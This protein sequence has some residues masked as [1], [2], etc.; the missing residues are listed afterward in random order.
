MVLIQNLVQNETIRVRKKIKNSF[1]YLFLL[2]GSI[3]LYGIITELTLL[4]TGQQLASYRGLD[5]VGTISIE[6]I[7]LII[8]EIFT[9]FASLCLGN[10]YELSYNVLLKAGYTIAFLFW[11]IESIICVYIVEPKTK[12]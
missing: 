12:N 3:I 1:K 8:K 2:V 5:N 11:L 7:G 6:K 9:C 4:I 10:D